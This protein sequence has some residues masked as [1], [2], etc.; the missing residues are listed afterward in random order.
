MDLGV[1]LILEYIG[2]PLCLIPF[3]IMLNSRYGASANI[4]CLNNGHYVG[5]K[6]VKVWHVIVIF[7]A[8]ITPVVNIIIGIILIVNTL[9]NLSLDVYR[10]NTDASWYKILNKKV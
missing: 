4:Y 6:I 3:L 7:I 8:A 1:I 10:I 5:E 2:F 9:S